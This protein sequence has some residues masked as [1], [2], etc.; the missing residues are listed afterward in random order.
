[1]NGLRKQR[2]SSQDEMG[3][4]D[5][6]EEKRLQRNSRLDNPNPVKRS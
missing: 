1:M 3:A 2:L 4:D 5:A 6:F